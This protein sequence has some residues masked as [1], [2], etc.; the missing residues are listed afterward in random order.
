VGLNRPDEVEVA[1]FL[2]HRD[3]VDPWTGS[4]RHSVRLDIPELPLVKGAF[5][6]YIFL[7]AEDGLHI[8]DTRIIEDAFAVS[9]DEYPFGIF[10]IRH[11]WGPGDEQ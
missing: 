6:L 9:Y 3:G 10:K 8:Y 2:S 11:S 1:S 5:K 7:L 4:T